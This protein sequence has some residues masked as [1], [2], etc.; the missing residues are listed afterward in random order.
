MNNPIGVFLGFSK[1]EWRIHVSI[2][3]FKFKW[4]GKAVNF[5][6]KHKIPINKIKF[7]GTARI[8][9]NGVYRGQDGNI[10]YVNV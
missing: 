10:W 7:F 2:F 8:L 9:R 3:H 1:K 6:V 4:K 5:C